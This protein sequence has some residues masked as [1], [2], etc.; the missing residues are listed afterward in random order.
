M[1]KP[2]APFAIAL[3]LIT[4][5]WFGQ[6]Y[7]LFT[8][9]EPVQAEDT[10]AKAAVNTVWR[11]YDAIDILL[12]TADASA[13]HAVIAP[14]FIDHVDEPSSPTDRDGLVGYLTSL[15]ETYPELRLVP[16]EVVAEGDQ[17]VARLR[18]PT[19][20]AARSWASRSSAKRPGRGSTCFASR[21]AGSSSAGAI[22]PG[23]RCRPCATRR[24]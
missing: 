9:V 13:L 1:P 4:G 24:R 16:Q 6:A 7:T 14:D 3:A 22:P 11:Y 17:V 18:Q 21:R 23:T 19:A 10:V 12:R 20:S 5:A 2:V 8:S 15:R